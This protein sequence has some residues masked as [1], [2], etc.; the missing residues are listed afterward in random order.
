MGKKTRGAPGRR[1]ILRLSPP[2]PRV[3][4]RDGPGSEDILV[5][6]VTCQTK[7]HDDSDTQ[8][9]PPPAS[10]ITELQPAVVKPNPSGLCL[11]GA[12]TDSDDEETDSAAKPTAAASRKANTSAD[13][14]STLANFLAVKNSAAL[15]H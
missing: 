2:G 5:S 4:S 11:L 3:T 12:Y 14:D 15:S 8:K 10:G 7:D 1:P 6:L 13:I 9:M